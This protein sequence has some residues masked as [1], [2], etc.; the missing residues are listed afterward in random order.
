MLMTALDG[1][2]L[3]RKEQLLVGESKAFIPECEKK[4]VE[5]CVE[6]AQHH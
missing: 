1:L 6:V 3:Q 2:P 5:S 4:W